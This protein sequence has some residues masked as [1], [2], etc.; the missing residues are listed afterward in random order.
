MSTLVVSLTSLSPIP[1]IMP[2]LSSLLATKTPLANTP[3]ASLVTIARL[4][5]LTSL[6]FSRITPTE[7]RN[8]ELYYVKYVAREISAASSKQEKMSVLGDNPR[9]DELCKIHGE[10][11]ATIEEATR[12]QGNEID[13]GTLEARLV[14][15]TFYMVTEAGVVEKHQE[16][17]HSMDIYQTKGVVG[18]LFGVR[19]LGCKL[20]WETEEL[21]RGS[22]EEW[23]CDEDEEDESEDGERASM[24][25]KESNFTTQPAQS[26]ATKSDPNATFP[27]AKNPVKEEEL[28]DGTRKLNYW[29]E[30]K[31]AR[32]RVV[33]R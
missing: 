1:T 2:A 17:P 15:F 11:P 12:D 10:L 28:V 29:I 3:S 13:P 5:A 7:R 6:N 16:L 33:L 32:V 20:V 24:D 18:R 23:S 21:D 25:E 30:D 8:A 19:P 27:L 4:P 31:V 22:Q 26:P 9:Y 14:K